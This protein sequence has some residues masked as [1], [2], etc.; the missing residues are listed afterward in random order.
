MKRDAKIGHMIS[1]FGLMSF[2]LQRRGD[3][4]SGVRR[5]RGRCKLEVVEIVTRGELRAW[6]VVSGPYHTAS[7]VT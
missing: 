7:E 6:T 2:R 1:I 5:G 4:C 3:I